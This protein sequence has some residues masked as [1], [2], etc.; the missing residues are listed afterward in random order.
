MASA[1]KKKAKQNFPGSSNFN[2]IVMGIALACLRHATRRLAHHQLRSD[3]AMS[4]GHFAFFQNRVDSLNHN[5]DG[6][7]THSLHGL[8]HGGERGRVQS[9]RGN[10]I[11]SDDRALFGH[12]DA[13][14]RQRADDAEGAHVVKGEQRREWA[15]LP[16]QV[17]GKLLPRLEAGDGIAGFRHVHDQARIKF[18]IAGLR[19]ISNAAPAWRTIGERLRAANK[20]DLAMTQGMKMFEG[21]ISPDFVIN[22]YGTD[23]IGFQF[24]SNHRGRNAALLQIGQQIKIEEKPVGQNNKRFDAAVEQHLEITLEAPAFVVYVGKDRKIRRL[25]SEEHTSELQ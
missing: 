7:S 4:G 14:F 9:R 21:Q 22:D 1:V 18:Q 24:E 10:I 19:A 15:L 2:K 13:G 16:D 11:E 8:A 20:S 3:L 6:G 17:F 5:S 12:A 25:R 23:G